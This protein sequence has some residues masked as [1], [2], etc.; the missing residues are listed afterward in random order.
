MITPEPVSDNELPPEHEAYV[1]ALL[2]EAPP[3][4]SDTRSR[5]IAVFARVPDAA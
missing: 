2:D 4:N 3:L 5:L 1:A